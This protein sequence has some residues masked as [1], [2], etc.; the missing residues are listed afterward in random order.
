MTGSLRSWSCLPFVC[1]A[2]TVGLQIIKNIAHQLEDYLKALYNENLVIDTD[3]ENLFLEAYD[4]LAIPLI[5]QIET[6]EFDRQEAQ[7]KINQVPEK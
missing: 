3:L 4:C 7:T 5:Q 2:A 1:G 6:G